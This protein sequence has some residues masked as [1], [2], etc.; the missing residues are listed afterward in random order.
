MN[1]ILILFFFAFSSNTMNLTLNDDAKNEVGDK[2][3]RYLRQNGKRLI[4]TLTINCREH[5]LVFYRNGN[6]KSI[7]VP[8]N[9][10]IIATLTEVEH[11]IKASVPDEKYKP[12]C[13][14]ETMFVNVSKWCKYELVNA[15][16]TRQ[17]L[18][19]NVIFGE[20]L[21]TLDLHVSHLY[22]GPHRNGETSSL[23][24]FVSK[25]AYEPQSNLYEIMSDSM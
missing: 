15:D 6:M 16:V 22:V 11:F 1:E 25:I 8:L 3:K 14:S 19:E 24:L 7:T 10:A 12:L 23:S 5:G 17:P 18:P 4:I 9:P 20:G 13:L 2:T 21:Y